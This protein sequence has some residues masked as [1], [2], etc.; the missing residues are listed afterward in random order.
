M[1]NQRL[2]FILLVAGAFLAAGCAS[3]S[4]NFQAK[5]VTDY[6]YEIT[7]D[8]YVDYATAKPAFEKFRPK[9]GGCSSISIGNL[10]GRNLDWTY[11]DGV[12]FVVRTT[13]QGNR[14]ASVG[15]ITAPFV[16]SDML[17]DGQYHEEFEMLPYTTMDG[18]NDAGICVNLNVVNFQEFGAWQMKTETTEDDMMELMSPRLILD[19]CTYLTDIVP[20]MEQ[21]DWF[22]LGNEEETHL[23][24]TGPRSADDPTLTNAILEY[25]PFTEDGKTFRKLCCISTDEKDIALVGGDASRFYHS[26]AD[27][28]IMTNFN[29]WQ[30][31]ASLDRKGRLLSATE[32]PMGF[33]RYETIEA[34]AKRAVSTAGSEENLTSV[35]MQDI[36]R[37]VYYSNNYN[38]DQP[39]YWYTEESKLTLTKEEI[40]NATDE[41]R[42]PCGDI[43][44]LIKG[45]DNKYVNDIEANIKAWAS[46]DRKVKNNLWE[47]LHTT[48][49]NYADRS[50][51][52][53]VHEGT[54]FYEYSIEK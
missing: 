8:D 38:L 4:H 10:R 7:L 52:V 42:Y 40:I 43:N 45:K 37:E 16:T 19:N 31:D 15:V 39:N 28:F 41:Q 30:F 50:L 33:E 51:Q 12:E 35:Q 3:G 49:Y 13:K 23:M 26:K 48:I 1:H 18:I 9:L 24:V 20:L 46:R 11:A 6:L 22:S 27:V 17:S 36:M 2:T 21:Y 29:L 14:H 44:K 54:I 32:H 34:A 5:K 47:T 25:I 53:N